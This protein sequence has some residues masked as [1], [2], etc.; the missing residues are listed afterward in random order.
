MKA[1]EP[2]VV[3][4]SKSAY[5]SLL[6]PLREASSTYGEEARL[7]D[8]VDPLWPPAVPELALWGLDKWGI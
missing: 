8:M 6:T 5:C 7:S 1:I 2:D 4:A 3:L